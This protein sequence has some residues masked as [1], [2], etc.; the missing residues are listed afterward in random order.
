M[1][2]HQMN[3]ILFSSFLSGHRTVTKFVE[4]PVSRNEESQK[5]CALEVLPSSHSQ[6][7]QQQSDSH[8]LTNSIP[9]Q[10]DI[11]SFFKTTKK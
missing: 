7:L 8:S 10:S 11:K 6:S 3:K 2:C 1:E 4:I 5:S 9:K